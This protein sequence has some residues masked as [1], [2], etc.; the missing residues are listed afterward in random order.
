M[1]RSNTINIGDAISD[2]IRE[3]RLD[4]GLMRARIYDAWDEV[5]AEFVSSSMSVEEARAL[6][7]SKFY[8]DKVLT[9]RITS[10][11]VRTHL[12]FQTEAICKRLNARLGS[13]VVTQ[14]ILV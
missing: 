12:S 10:S 11:M 6:T 8:K 9:C 7:S 3:C 4:S 2:Y 13:T 1:R 14:L 5:I